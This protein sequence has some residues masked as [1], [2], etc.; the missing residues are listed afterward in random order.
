MYKIKI[1]K[2]SGVKAQIDDDIVKFK[3]YFESKGLSLDLEITSTVIPKAN[4]PQALFY[5]NDGLCDV[6][7]Y[8]YNRGDFYD[9][10][11]G[12]AF[13]ITNKLRGVYLATSIADDAVDYTWKSMAHEIM[14]T[15]FY[16]LKAQTILIDDPMDWFYRDGQLLRYYKNEDLNAP[17][18]N[19]AES[20]KR[21]APFMNLLTEKS[22]K[23][24][25]EYEIKKYQ[26]TPEMWEKL[27]KAREIAGVPFILTS[28]R[29]SKGQNALV[30]GVSTSSHLTGEGCD[31]KCSTSQNRYKI[32]SALIQV[33]FNRIG[34][35][36]NHIH[37]D[38]STDNEHP[39]NIVWVSNKN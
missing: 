38:I 36:N 28:G 20:W 35:Y 15:L 26:L 22:Y 12:L 5:P 34:I 8:L 10:S 33:G 18:G 24:F 11:F 2:H 6:V 31:L 7:M 16:K 4:A 30:G 29:R 1:Y 3:G 9:T 32:V 39:Q 14:H 13:N 27:D 25:S 17:D 21:L 19:F 23:H 37:A